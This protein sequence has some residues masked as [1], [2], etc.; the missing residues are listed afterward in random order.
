MAH[1]DYIILYYI[2]LAGAIGS[3]GPSTMVAYLLG[4]GVLLTWLRQ[5]TG[6]FTVAEQKLEGNFRY[7]N[8]RL[9]THSE[10]IA[11]YHGNER[12]QSVLTKSFTRLMSLVRK[13]QQ[14]RFSMSIIDNIVAKVFEYML[15]LITW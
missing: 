9:I 2:K 1:D 7:M 15:I 10:E 11:F 6:K 12:E 13:S 14:F 5:P 4:S 8:S 3:K